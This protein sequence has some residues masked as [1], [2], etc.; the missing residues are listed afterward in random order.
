MSKSIIENIVQSKIIAPVVANILMPKYL[1]SG[2]KSA[3]EFLEDMG[4][5]NGM[6]GLNFSFYHVS[7][8]TSFFN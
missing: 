1:E 5:E 4:V 6:S 7:K 8:I 2:D 3:N